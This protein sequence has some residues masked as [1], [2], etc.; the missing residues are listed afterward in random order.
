MPRLIRFTRSFSPLLVVA[1]VLPVGHSLAGDAVKL[2]TQCQRGD[3]TRVAVTLNVEGEMQVAGEGKSLKLPMHVA[4]ALKYDEMRLDDSASPMS[5]RSARCYVSAGAKIEIENHTDI[6]SL[7]AERRLVLV[8]SGKEGIVISSLSG[9]LTREELELID[10]PA[11]SLVI[12]AILP[13]EAVQP[14][15]SWDPSAEFIGRLLGLDAVA[16]SDVKCTLGEI[17]ESNAEIGIAGKLKGAVGGVETEIEL[18]GKGMFDLDKNRLVSIQLRIKERRSPGFVS[19]GFR[20][21]ATLKMDISALAGSDQLTEDIAK[22]IAAEPS[23]STVESRGEAAA[24]SAPLA[25]QSKA[26]AYQ[27]LYD[28]RWHL[29]RDE[30]ELAVLRFVDRGELIA[31]CNIS[32]LAKLP[33]ETRFTLENFQ[34]DVEHVLGERLARFDSAAERKTSTGLRLLK[35]VVEG[36]ASDLSIEWR[37]YL[38][39]DPEGRRVALTFTME[40]NLVDRFANADQMIV[41]SLEMLKAEQNTEDAARVIHLR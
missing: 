3:L 4:G 23:P 37:Y 34:S 10:M 40:S 20:V 11:N 25:L 9:P 19:P 26:G 6:S 32:P 2:Q 38:A 29:T 22:S 16:H 17:H 12:D 14:G 36:T 27:L 15:G 30:P 41:E 39:I 28:R 33:A 8:N 5:R 1:I 21:V 24:E 13:A 31:Q 35:V 7:R 18:D